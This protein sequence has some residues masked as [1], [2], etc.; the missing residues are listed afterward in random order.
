MKEVYIGMAMQCTVN[1]TLSATGVIKLCA[2][3]QAV[4]AVLLTVVILFSRT[5]L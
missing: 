4:C 2:G 3:Q 5:K 1:A